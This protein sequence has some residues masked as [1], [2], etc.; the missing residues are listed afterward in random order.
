ML[1]TVAV[2]IASLIQIAWVKLRHGKVDKTLWISAVLVVVLGC[3][4]LYLQDD[5]FI[6]WKP[7]ILYW[8]FAATIL[9]A[10]GFGIKISSAP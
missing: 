8:L 2:I 10:N 5:A 9:L 6:K 1:A 4:T 7:T 3:L